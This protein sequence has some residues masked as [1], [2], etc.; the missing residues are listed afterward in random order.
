MVFKKMN[1][2][3]FQP[4]WL[5]PFGLILSLIVQAGRRSYSPNGKVKVKMLE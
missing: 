3:G 1:R 4:V 5:K 2:K